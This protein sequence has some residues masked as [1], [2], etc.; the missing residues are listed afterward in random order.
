MSNSLQITFTCVDND[1]KVEVRNYDA[2]PTL[3]DLKKELVTSIFLHAIKSPV[4]IGSIIS[5]NGETR[6]ITISNDNILKNTFEQFIEL[7]KPVQIY[8]EE[9]RA[10]EPPQQIPI[11]IPSGELRWHLSAPGFR[12]PTQG[13]GKPLSSY[14]R[15][16]FGPKL[17][18]KPGTRFTVT[19]RLVN[20]GTQSWPH[21]LSFVYLS[22]QHG[23]LM[24]ACETYPIYMNQTLEPYQA[25]DISL[26][27]TAP[28]RP[29]PYH[30][31]WKLQDDQGK[32]VGVRVG[33]KIEVMY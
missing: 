27:L 30:S 22:K 10:P 11:S 14:S 8:V 9:E 15:E 5:P 4:L 23:T 28:N 17:P 18:L 21:S 1:F 31:Y 33:L 26:G 19:W 20:D 7:Q 32:P 6:R 29:G 24:G 3:E 16:Q 2:I 25:V 13:S 12:T